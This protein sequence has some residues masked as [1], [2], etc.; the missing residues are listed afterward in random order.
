MATADDISFQVS[1]HG[2]K[3]VVVVAILFRFVNL[4]ADKRRL[5]RQVARLQEQQPRLTT[6]LDQDCCRLELVY[7]H[8]LIEAKRAELDLAVFKKEN[9][10]MPVS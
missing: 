9:F 10:G 5:E 2:S 7:L 4:H 3:D 6:G 8:C 1:D